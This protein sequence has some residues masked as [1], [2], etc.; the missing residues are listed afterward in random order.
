MLTTVVLCVV[1]WALGWWAFG[2]PVR[3]ADLRRS[4]TSGVDLADV[5]VIVPARDEERSLPALLDALL[6]VPGPGSPRIVV[7]DDQSTDGTRAAAT[8]Q[9]VEVVTTTALPAGWAGKCWACHTGAAAAGERGTLVFLD[10]DVRIDPDGLRTVVEQARRRGGL[11]SV[12]P[13]H[14]APRPYEQASALFNVIAVMGTALGRRGSSRA[15]AFGPVLATSV[16]DYR[17]AGG[18]AAVRSEVVEDL[19][20]AQRYRAASLPVAAVAGG[21]AVSFRMYPGGL[22]QLVDGWTKNFAL[23]AADTPLA[24]LAAVVAWIAGLGTA[25]SVLLDAARGRVAWAAAA[26]LYALFVAQLWSMFRAVG[27]FG[28]LTAVL[29]PLPATVFVAVFVRSLWR[30]H[31]RHSVEWRGRTLSTRRPPASP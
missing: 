12:Q 7:V 9:G 31:V 17:R 3:L 21:T 2:R 5:T 19:A 4:S 22:R 23:G 28:L 13:W 14:D 16:E 20:L 15:V 1:A 8:R 18:H 27:R 10:A 24:R 29:Y 30:T 11:F 26:A 25:V 6:P